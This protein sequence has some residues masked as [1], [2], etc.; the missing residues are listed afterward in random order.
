MDDLDDVAEAIVDIEDIVEEIAD[1][2]ELLD[3]LLDDPLVILFGLVAGFAALIA[4]LLLLLTVALLVLAIGPVEVVA[5]LT[6]LCFL[7]MGLA[8]GGFLYVRTDIPSDVQRKIDAALE[9]ADETPKQNGSMTEEEAITELKNQYANGEID[10]H[11]LDQALEDALTSD[12][13]EKV[14]SRYE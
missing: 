14:V 6:V 1:P 9:R 12:Q 7:A 2:E 10:D 8:I 13:P 5:L 3:D 11:E 4:A